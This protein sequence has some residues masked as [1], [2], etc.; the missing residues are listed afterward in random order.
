MI[1]ITGGAGFIGSAMLWHLNQQGIS[2]AF[3]VDELSKTEKWQNL[4][5]LQFSEYFHKNE[6]LDYLLNEKNSDI[7]A[8]I[9]MGA[10]SATTETDA[11]LL[12]KNNFEYTKSLALFSVQHNIRFIYASSAATY[13]NGDMGYSDELAD[14]FKLRPLNMYG[15][16][17]HLFDLWAIKNEIINKIVGLKFF[18][19][20]GPNEYHKDDMTSVVFKAYHQILE[21]GKVRLFKSHRPDFTD[22]GQSRDFVYVK[23]C[24]KVMQ[25]LMEN[26]Q[27]NGVY[28]IGT[29]KAR[30]FYDLTAATFAAMDKPINIEYFPMPEHLQGKYQYFTQADMSKLQQAGCPVTFGS[31]EENVKDYVQNHLMQ[32]IPYLQ[33]NISQG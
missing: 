15:Y 2:D 1:V 28:N 16:S 9:H 3:V 24:L 30:S 11:D 32:P 17:K 6:F 7:D 4:A 22:G 26:P 19:V 13:G 20:F 10:I 5:G 18:N 21:T 27:V 8:I 29:G 33:S 14:T 31:L 25:W 12:M 23:D